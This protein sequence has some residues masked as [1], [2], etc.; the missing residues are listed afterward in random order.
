[1]SSPGSNLRSARFQRRLLIVAFAVLAAGVIAFAISRTGGDSKPAAAPAQTGT[2]KDVSKVP[3]TVKLDP[4][5]TQVA[6]LF[7]QTAVARKNLAKA[8]PLAGPAI[9]QGQ[10]LKE[11]LTGNIA[12]VPYPLEDLDIAPMKIDYSYKNEALIEVALLPKN[13]AKIKSQ[14][15]YMTLERVGKPKHW[16]VNSW[17]PRGEPPVP[18][19]D[20]NC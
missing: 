6:K 2:V 19:G 5:A 9:R 17:V 7:I 18:C 15:F 10:S 1:M 3:K 20:V 14:L 4:K 12:V 11:W 13:G 8:Y 16:V